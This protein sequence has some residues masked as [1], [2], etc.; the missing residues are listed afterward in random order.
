[1][2]DPNRLNRPVRRIRGATVPN[3]RR[4]KSRKRLNTER[5]SCASAYGR[6]PHQIGRQANGNSALFVH[7]IVSCHE[8]SPADVLNKT[9]R[10]HNLI[11]E[12]MTNPN[13]RN[14]LM[15]RRRRRLRRIAVVYRSDR[16]ITHRVL[17]HS[18]C[19]NVRA[20]R[21]RVVRLSRC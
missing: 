18:L 5:A 4:G 10:H 1:M 19:I 11:L 3:V 6:K 8:Y 12:P 7:V 14:G 20:F 21:Q 13:R 15:T 9:R 2:A 17:I 16:P